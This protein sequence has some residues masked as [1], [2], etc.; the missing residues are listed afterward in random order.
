MCYL[1]TLYAQGQIELGLPVPTD[2]T[3]EQGEKIYGERFSVN[4]VGT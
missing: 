1:N 3:Q 2:Q 4:F